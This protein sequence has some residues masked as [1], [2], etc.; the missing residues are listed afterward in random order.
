MHEGSEKKQAVPNKKDVNYARGITMGAAQYRQGD[1]E[2]LDFTGRASELIMCLSEALALTTGAAAIAL[3]CHRK[4]A[5]SAMNSLWW[6]GMVRW[7]N[8]FAEMGQYQGQFRLWYRADARPP[9]DAQEACRLAALGLFYALAKKE[10]PGF[11]W[12]VMRNGKNGILAEM[13]FDSNSGANKW[14]I[15]APRRDENPHPQADVYIFPTLLEGETLTPAGKMYTADELLF[16]PGELRRK[17]FR[18]TP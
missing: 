15:D 11:K 1:C 12:Q 13:Q 5:G 7:V 3:S 9:R 8:V 2:S 6:S 16:E 10:V 18:K 17:I 4:V 14:L